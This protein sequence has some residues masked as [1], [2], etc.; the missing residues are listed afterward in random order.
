MKLSPVLIVVCMALCCLSAGCSDEKPQRICTPGSTQVCICKTGTSGVQSCEENGMYWRECICALE[1]DGG[2]KD[3]AFFPE[4]DLLGDGKQNEDGVDMDIGGPTDAACQGDATRPCYTGKLGT[5]EVGLCKKG[6]QTCSSG[7]WS[8]CTGEVVPAAEICDNQDNDCNGSTD[9][10]VTQAC[11]TGK[12]GT[13]GV[14]LCKKGT[15]TCSSGSWGQCKGEI[16]PIKEVCDGKDNNCDGKKDEVFD[17]DDCKEKCSHTWINNGGVFRCCGDDSNEA[18]PYVTLENAIC[19][20]RDNDCDGKV[21]E[22][23]WIKTANLSSSLTYVAHDNPSIAIDAKNNPHVTWSG[24][25]TYSSSSL[26]WYSGFNGKNWSF[27]EW[28]K[29]G[30]PITIR[31]AIAV[32]KNGYPCVASGSGGYLTS[33]GTFI[34]VKCLSGKQWKNLGSLGT[35]YKMDHYP[36]LSFD[37]SG[38]LHMSWDDEGQVYHSCH[39]GSTWT[40]SFI[41]GNGPSL[42]HYGRT[43]MLA[44]GNK[45]VVVVW[46]GNTPKSWDVFS[47]SFN[48]SSWSS[49]NNVTNNNGNSLWPDIALDKKNNIHLV[50][51]DD[52]LKPG[53]TDYF[54]IYYRKYSGNKWSSVINISNNSTES[55]RPSVVVSNAEIAHVFWLDG[56]MGKPPLY[57]RRVGGASPK[58]I[59]GGFSG[60]DMVIDSIGDV[61]VVSSNY[62]SISYSKYICCP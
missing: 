62:T 40:P 32:D 10:G 18:N 35:L 42:Q 2:A 47:R 1:N 11:Y 22:G 3:T 15:Q 4:L 58:Q 54:E 14:G 44:Y 57:Y 46:S 24:R 16:T 43:S 25:K 9:D 45:H 23:C 52:V 37:D 7:K 55:V 38:N 48:G 26:V 39:N 50:W 33:G 41:L 13:A 60:Y 6:T 27:P 34:N 8:G 53:E 19:D 20:G 12:P 51:Y 49:L 61:H 56:N 36:T 31:P 17:E 5:S 59:G 28:L 21:D 30:A 29:M